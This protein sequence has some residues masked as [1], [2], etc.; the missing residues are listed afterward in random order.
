MTKRCAWLVLVVFAGLL[1]ACGEQDSTGKKTAIPGRQVVKVTQNAYSTLEM[2]VQQQRET[3]QNK[4]TAQV[5]RLTRRIEKV[6]ARIEKLEG[7]LKSKL[8]GSITALK[9][10]RDAAYAKLE[11]IKVETDQNWELLKSE[12]DAALDEMEKDY[13]KVL[14]ALP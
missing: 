3:Y 11:K 6:Q 7:Q 9:G 5:E 2:Y 12:L 8:S 14:D 10:K 4:V 13:D 1:A